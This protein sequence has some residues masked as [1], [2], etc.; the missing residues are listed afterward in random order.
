MKNNNMKKL[1]Y[2]VNIKKNKLR[3]YRDTVSIFRSNTLGFSLA[4]LV[5]VLVLELG[6][7]G[8]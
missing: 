8:W 2:F 5:G 3:T 7:H 6:T 1:G 4:L